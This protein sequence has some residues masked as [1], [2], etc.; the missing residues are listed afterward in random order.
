MKVI[1]IS[2]VT[3]TRNLHVLCMCYGM[4]SSDFV[5]GKKEI[6]PVDGREATCRRLMNI[7]H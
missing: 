6:K 7:N 1:P 5:V 3:R 2:D 4:V